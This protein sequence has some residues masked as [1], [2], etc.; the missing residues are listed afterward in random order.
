M[1]IYAASLRC[2]ALLISAVAVLADE[3]PEGVQKLTDVVP[4]SHDR[5]KQLSQQMLQRFHNCFEV[6]QA[7]CL[8]EHVIK[9]TANQQ[10]LVG[11]WTFDLIEPVDES[12]NGNHILDTVDAGP[13]ST[14]HGSSAIF[15]PDTSYSVADSPSLG[16]QEFTLDLRVYLL[17]TRSS[18]F[19]NVIS[20]RSYYAQS[21][22]VMLYP[23]SNRL[24]IRVSTSNSAN[25]GMTSNGTV[26][27]RRW[28]Q[29]TVVARQRTLKLYI[30]GS[31]DSAIALRGDLVPGAGDLFFGRKL[32]I[33]GFKGYMDD[34]KLYNY[35]MGSGLIASLS[36][37]NLTGI[38]APF[39]IQLASTHCSIQEA[40]SR[41]LCATGCKLCT[42]DQL[43]RGA[44]HAA[45]VNG[46][47]HDSNRVW[48]VGIP[49]APPN[50]KHAA[51]CCC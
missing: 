16:V 34:V 31:L 21:P 32:D 44:A 6:G 35:A 40:S 7:L 13:P 38:V 47:L 3:E 42:L 33:Q 46:W 22:T 41:G 51:L 5:L 48:H 37:P 17:E 36:H 28:T 30:N 29:L 19:R 39:R 2:V 15:D 14:G 50:E 20:R 11:H 18:G 9:S 12:G 23:Q 8:G 43:Y 1:Y 49:H 26:P 45:R 10:G 27:P 24:S 25:E 4:E